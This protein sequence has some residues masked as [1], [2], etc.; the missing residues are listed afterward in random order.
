MSMKNVSIHCNWFFILSARD[1]NYTNTDYSC[2]LKNN[3][4]LLKTV[5][6]I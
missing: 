2:F 3:V 1:K 5:T 6:K 4:T